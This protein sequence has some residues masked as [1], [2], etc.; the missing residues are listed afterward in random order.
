MLQKYIYPYEYMDDLEK[1][2]DFYSHLSMEDITDA[3]Y[4]HAERVCRNFEIKSLGECYDLYVQSNK[5]LFADVF[6]NVRNM[7]LEIYEL[8]P[9][10][11]FHFFD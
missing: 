8:A 6:E 10:K 5:L 4:Q 3:N 11:F 9:A 2:N 1:F 7:W